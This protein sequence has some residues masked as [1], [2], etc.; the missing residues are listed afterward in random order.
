M[1]SCSL[2]VSDFRSAPI[3]TLS[4]AS[5]KS[6][7]VTSARPQQR[8]IENIRS[9]GRRDDDNTGADRKAIHFDEQLIQRLLAL[10]VAQRIAAAAPAD[11]IELVDEHDAGGMAARV[12]EQLA[13]T[14]GADA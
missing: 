6:R 3:R 8:G 11:R 14:R 13:D 1:R 7:S 5:S 4:R 10:F 2:I 12:L 9:I